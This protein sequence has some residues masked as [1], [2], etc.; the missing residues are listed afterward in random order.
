METTSTLDQTAVDQFV[1]HLI[2]DLGAALSAVLIH[3]GDRLGLYRAMSDAT[4]VTSV[5]LAA[6]TGLA[7]RY[8]REWLHNQAAAGW[9]RYDPNTSTFTLPAEHAL[10]LAD[11]DSPTFMLGG[12]D[13]VAAAWA[14]EQRLVEAFRTGAGIGWH[15]HDQRLFTGTERFFRPGYQANLV[16]AWLPALD[17]VVDRLRPG[18]PRSPTSAA[19]TARRP[20]SWARPTR[21]ALS[22]DSTTTT[23][24]SPR[25]AAEPRTPASTPT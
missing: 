10:L 9:V 4:P 18:H 19:A 11:E 15:E 14:D 1:H 7:E 21:T 13:F 12:F 23:P 2:G 8:L 16:Q 6:K 20:C 17:G 25:P 22:S 5:D 24:R 3:I